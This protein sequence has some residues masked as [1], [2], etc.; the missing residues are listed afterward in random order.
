[1]THKTDILFTYL[2][3]VLPFFSN[4]WILIVLY[5]FDIE[6]WIQDMIS[7]ILYL[8]TLMGTLLYYTSTYYDWQG[9]VYLGVL[10]VINIIM[11]LLYE[12]LKK[13]KI[14]QLLLILIFL[15]IVLRLFNILPLR[16]LLYTII[17]GL[18]GTITK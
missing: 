11:F 15:G 17:D 6:S 16:Y 4:L 18:G 10:M 7:P 5:K 9:D 13:S 8:V 3:A 1:M 12:D 2:L 14:R